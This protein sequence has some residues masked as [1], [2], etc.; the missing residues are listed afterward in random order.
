MGIANRFFGHLMTELKAMYWEYLCHQSSKHFAALA[1]VFYSH[2]DILFQSSSIRKLVKVTRSQ[3]SRREFA[4]VLF[5]TCH[6]STP[7]SVSTNHASWFRVFH[8]IVNS[9]MDEG[10]CITLVETALASVDIMWAPLPDGSPTL[11]VAK[12]VRKTTVDTSPQPAWKRDAKEAEMELSRGDEPPRKRIIDFGGA[13][14]IE[15]LPVTLYNGF[16]VMIAEHGRKSP[17]VALHFQVARD[18]ITRQI[19]QGDHQ[20][21][22]LLLLVLTLSASTTTP[23]LTARGKQ[24]TDMQKQ[25]FDL[26]NSRK[27]GPRFA[28]VLATKMVWFLQP[29]VFFPPKILLVKKNKKDKKDKNVMSSTQ[30]MKELLGSYF[31]VSMRLNHM[32]V[33]NMERLQNS[34]KLVTGP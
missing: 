7:R 6:P 10:S 29:E 8:H 22:L 19:G 25:G 28:A 5:N 30:D 2:H 13:R 11:A 4:Q 31:L 3:S 20:I 26:S 9:G 33:A 1:N 32:E 17:G 34:I 27:E 21:S 23:W 12:L 18:Y 14:Q 15:S 24:L 16:E